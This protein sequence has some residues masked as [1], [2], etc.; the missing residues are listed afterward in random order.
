M[1]KF[2]TLKRSEIPEN[3]HL[4]LLHNGGGVQTGT[5]IE[6]IA[7]GIMERPTAVI[8]A[9]TGD[10]P[11][12][13]H[14]QWARDEMLMKRIGVPYLR[15]SNGSLHNDL[16]D[17]GRFAAMPLYTKTKTEMQGFGISAEMITTGKMKRQCTHEYKITPIE[18]EIRIILLEMGL[19]Y[20]RKNGQIVVKNGVNVESWIGYTT[21]EIARVKP[22]RVRWQYFRFPLIEMRMSKGDCIMWLRNNNKPPRLSSF[23]IK[24]PLI[25]PDQE[26]QLKE[27]DPIGWENRLQFDS[28]LRDPGSPLR[29][30]A[31]AHGELFVSKKLIPLREIDIYSETGQTS[32]E[33]SN[34]G[35]M[36]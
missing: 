8:Q 15:V 29:I 13:I 5:M 9:D 30:A 4:V 2:T 10:E 7:D 11:E 24:C 6:M 27:N 17:G 26:K 34:V 36:T 16:Y 25:G 3:P 22:P 28:D 33:C 1:A 21:D 35:C 18:R 32:F 12:Y 23:C 31:T 20:E 14:H 19:A